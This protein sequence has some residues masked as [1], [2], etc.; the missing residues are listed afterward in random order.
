MVNWPKVNLILVKITEGPDYLLQVAR[1]TTGSTL[2]RLGTRTAGHSEELSGAR[3]SSGGSGMPVHY[4][5]QS[6]PGW[7]RCQLR[8]TKLRVSVRNLA[9]LRRKRRRF[10]RST[11]SVRPFAVVN[12]CSAAATL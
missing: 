5:A 7:C 9:M 8:R 3:V 2:Y 12:V 10:A 11:L 6:G 4:G 1:D